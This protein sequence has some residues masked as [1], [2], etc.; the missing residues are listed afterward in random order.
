MQVNN[1]LNVT[2]FSFVVIMQQLGCQFFDGAV[3][4]TCQSFDA[5]ATL[6]RPRHGI[7]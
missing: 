5:L 1:E 2:F 3:S 7:F 6:T 4:R